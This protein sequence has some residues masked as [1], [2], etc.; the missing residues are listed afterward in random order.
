MSAQEQGPYSREFVALIEH[1]EKAAL[2]T[3]GLVDDEEWLDSG[4][5]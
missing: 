4:G 2:L 5:N 1:M 3:D